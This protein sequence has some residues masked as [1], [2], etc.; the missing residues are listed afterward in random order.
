MWKTVLPILI[1]EILEFAYGKL[2][3]FIEMQRKLAQQKKENRNEVDE[4][5]K[6]PDALKRA[7]RMRDFLK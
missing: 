3:E 5:L 7:Q 1:K 6:E 2:R 4:I